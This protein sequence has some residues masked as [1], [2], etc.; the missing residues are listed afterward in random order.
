MLLNL[1][2][3][4]FWCQMDRIKSPACHLK[5][6]CILRSIQ[7]KMLIFRYCTCVLKY[8]LIVKSMP[9]NVNKYYKIY[10]FRN[11]WKLQLTP[12]LQRRRRRPLKK[13]LHPRAIHHNWWNIRSKYLTGILWN[14]GLDYEIY[15]YSQ[16][17]RLSLLINY[18]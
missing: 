12:S 3:L 18:D 17:T 11:Y 6:S 1:S 13:L 10:F 8:G 4:Y 15:F 2:S 7:L 9:E 16:P 5:K 14:E